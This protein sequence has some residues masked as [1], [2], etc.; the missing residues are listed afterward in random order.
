M[1][2][3]PKTDLNTVKRVPKRGQYDKETIYDIVDDALICH[4]SFVFDGRPMIIPTI[5]ARQGDTILLHGATSSR[6]LRHIATG[7]DLCIA[8]THLDGLVLARSVFHHSM[9]YRSA[10][11]FGKGEL[12]DDPEKKMAAL[13][14]FT[15]KLIPGRWDDARPPSPTEAKAT[16]IVRIPI[17]SASAKVRVGPPGDDDKDYALDVWAGVLP[18]H[19]VFG[20]LT[21]D[22]LLKAGV[23][24]PDYLNDYAQSLKR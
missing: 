5:H 17:E 10:V 7:A 4:V 19:T 3:F 24:A 8:V 13:K 18:M 21:A 20:D 22:P 15:E 11:L 12:I 14:I 2:T 16:H 6:M 1:E 9:N 23:E